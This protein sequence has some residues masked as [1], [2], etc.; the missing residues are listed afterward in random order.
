MCN[1]LGTHRFC[2][3]SNQ[4]RLLNDAV[5]TPISLQFGFSKL[6][7]CKVLNDFIREEK[8]LNSPIKLCVGFK[9]KVYH[10]RKMAHKGAGHTPMRVKHRLVKT[11]F[12]IFHGCGF[13]RYILLISLR[14][15]SITWRNAILK[16]ACS[17]LIELFYKY[18]F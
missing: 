17:S 1:P 8:W 14:P 9:G 6:C 16:W 2:I 4:V 11:Q 10:S 18:I 7:F 13:L 5:H 3:Q 12:M 15:P